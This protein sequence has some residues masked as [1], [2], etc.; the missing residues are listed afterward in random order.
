MIV[1]QE[2]LVTNCSVVFRMDFYCACLPNCYK[3]L[4]NFTA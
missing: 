1:V 3:F 2:L 4:A